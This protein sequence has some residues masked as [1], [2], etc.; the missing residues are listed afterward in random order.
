MTFGLE[1]SSRISIDPPVLSHK[2]Q[3]IRVGEE[4]SQ[5]TPL[6]KSKRDRFPVIVQFFRVASDL[7]NF[8]PPPPRS[9]VKQQ[10]PEIVQLISVGE[11]S[12]ENTALLAPEFP[13]IVQFKNVGE[14]FSPQYTPPARKE[15]FAVIAQFKNV[16]EEF[17]KHPTPVP[18]FAVIRQFKIVGEEFLSHH[19]PPREFR[20]IMQ[21]LNVGEALSHNTPIV[22]PQASAP[23]VRVKPSRIE[24][25]FSPLKVTTLLLS[26]DIRIVVSPA[27]S[28]PRTVMALPLNVIDSVISYS[29]GLTSTVSPSCAASM[30]GWISL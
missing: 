2:M 21:S 13:E 23:A 25:S 4:S 26:S 11:E 14:E 18:Q 12:L 27:H 1:T 20:V 10:F 7:T 9:R 22:G 30:A 8:K 15:M 17:M 29:P 28:S 19:T 16:G 6:R 3:L 24:A 5:I